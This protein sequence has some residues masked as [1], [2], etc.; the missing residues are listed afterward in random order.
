MLFLCHVNS[1][2]VTRVIVINPIKSFYPDYI[3]KLYYS[4]RGQCYY[5]FLHGY[6]RRVE[7]LS[8]FL[9]RRMCYSHFVFW[10]DIEGVFVHV[11]LFLRQKNLLFAT[12]QFLQI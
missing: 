8:T 7:S 3:L 1:L 4:I 6:L 9:D 2:S 5:N 10:G 11:F 12:L